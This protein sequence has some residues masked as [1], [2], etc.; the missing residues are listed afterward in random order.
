MIVNGPV[1][2]AGMQ[3]VSFLRLTEGKDRI[4]RVP[5]FLPQFLKDFYELS[6]KAVRD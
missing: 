2:N 6:G 3:M 4:L 1:K 5:S